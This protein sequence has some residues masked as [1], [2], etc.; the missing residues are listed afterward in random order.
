MEG[1]WA[2]ETCLKG[3]LGL[4]AKIRNLKST[5]YLVLAYSAQTRVCSKIE[6]TKFSILSRVLIIKIRDK[7][8]ILEIGENT[9]RNHFGKLKKLKLCYTGYVVRESR[10]K[11][12]R[13]LRFWE[14]VSG[15]RKVERPLTKWVDE[16][17]CVA[18]PEKASKARNYKI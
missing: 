2:Q 5:I 16:V 7:I 17:A 4:R 18:G 15:K 13:R 8:R 9:L 3:I 10:L 14:P 11:P 1:I 12:N 6:L